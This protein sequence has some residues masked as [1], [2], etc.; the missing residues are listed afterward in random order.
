MKRTQNP[1]WYKLTKL[2][3]RQ[4]E[5]TTGLTIPYIWGAYKLLGKPLENIYELLDEICQ[6]SIDKYPI[7]QKCE[8]IHQHVIAV[9]EK[10]THHKPYLKDTILRN[11]KNEI[12]LIISSNTNLGKTKNEI[13]K[14]L[15]LLYAKHVDS[16][17]F[18]WHFREQEWKPFEKE[19]MERILS[20]QK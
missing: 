14:N 1:D 9:E 15:T 19:E 18:S 4:G 16:G 20:I 7:I 6:N 10:N 3:K 13:Y 17:T 11:E 12:E 2:L 8:T 5:I